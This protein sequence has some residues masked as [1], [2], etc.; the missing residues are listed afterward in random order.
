MKIAIGTN[1][2]DI[3]TNVLPSNS[4]EL[5]V[6]DAKT[7][8][9]KEIPS[10]KSWTFTKT[11]TRDLVNTPILHIRGMQKMRKISEEKNYSITGYLKP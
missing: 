2:K 5:A 7:F 4:F 9:H 11:Q 3:I 8:F 1:Y 6:I 10:M